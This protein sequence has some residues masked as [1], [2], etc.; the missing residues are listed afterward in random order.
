MNRITRILTMSG[1]GL[2]TGLTI[3][4]GPA[5]ATTATGQGMSP[6]AAGATETQT[7]DHRFD[8]DRDRSRIAGVYDSYR[9]CDWAG[10][11]G[12]RRDRWDDYNCYPRG[13]GWHRRWILKVSWDHDNFGDDDNDGPRWPRR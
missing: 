2:V 8:R 6:S 3:G 1:L 11:R 10:R 13:F 4:V 9:E 7:V 12:E 5:S